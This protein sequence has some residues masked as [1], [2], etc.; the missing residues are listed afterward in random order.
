MPYTFV[1]S[2]ADTTEDI[3]NL[4]AGVYTVTIT[5]ISGCSYSTSLNVTQP[6]SALL[7][8]SVITDAFCL[9]GNLGSVQLNVLGG[10]PSYNYLWNDNSVAASLNNLSAGNYSV[11]VT[12]SNNC[13]LSQSFTISDSSQAILSAGGPASFCKGGNVALTVNGVNVNAYQWYRDGQ[14][15]TNANSASYVASDEGNYSVVLTSTC[16]TFA[17]DTFAVTVFDLPNIDITTS[18][19]NCAAGAQLNVSGGN[20]YQWNPATGLNNSTIYNPVAY[21]EA[22]TEYTVTVT[23]DNGCTAYESI[24]VIVDCDSIS[25]PNGFS[26]DGDGTN[27]T[28]VIAGLE[29]FPDNEVQVFNRWGNIV[30]EKNNYD[31]SWNGAS[32]KGSLNVIGHELP[33]GTYYYILNV[34]DGKKPRAGFVVLNR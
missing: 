6:D 26:P 31:N 21:P 29:K 12:D 27:D 9:G 22:T 8:T 25:I 2:T 5:D 19:Y 17:S 7:I 15:I 32:N 34:K 11:T 20:D 10:T 23:D 30:Y 33:S 28:W 1:W 3:S 16:G 4:V 24:T 13:V 14:I 18:G